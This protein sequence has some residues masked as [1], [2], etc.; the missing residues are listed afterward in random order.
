[1]TKPNINFYIRSKWDARFLIQTIMDLIAKER[2]PYA[3]VVTAVVTAAIRSY[4]RGY[5]RKVDTAQEAGIYQAL[6]DYA[7]ERAAQ[8][9]SDLEMM[10]R[11]LALLDWTESDSYVWAFDF[12]GWNIVKASASFP[13]DCLNKE[14]TEIV[15]HR[16]W[17]RF[18]AKFYISDGTPE[19]GLLVFED[20]NGE[21]AFNEWM[22]Q[23]HPDLLHQ[24]LDDDSV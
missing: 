9:S 18:R 3:D 5:S 24:T 16:S 20:R 15:V 22:E 21:E 10:E 1:M 12:S 23:A 8:R 19:K 13:M 14:Q 4:S 17:E 11:F 2:G 6:K 7:N